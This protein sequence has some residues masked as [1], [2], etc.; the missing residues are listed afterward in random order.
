MPASDAIIAAIRV[1]Y[2]KRYGEPRI[3]PVEA[4]RVRDYLL[5]MNESARLPDGH[6]VPALFLLT[7]GRTRRPQPARGTAVN[8][9]DDFEFFAPVY[10]GDT[11]RIDRRVLGVDEK[12]GKV[13]RMYLTRAEAD[14]TNQHGTLVARAHLNTLRWGL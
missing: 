12:E 10:I 4:G 8:A 1:D 13:G 11:I 6:P 7:L 5:A 14:Y 9:G 3:E 2:A